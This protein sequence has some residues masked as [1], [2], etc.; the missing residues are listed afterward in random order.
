MTENKELLEQQAMEIHQQLQTVE[1]Q[2][3]DL[4]K[5]VEDINEISK[6]KNKQILVPIHNGVFIKAK[7]EDSENFMVN[8]GSNISVKK[9]KKDTQDLLEQQREE[10]SNYKQQLIN[11][12]EE[13]AKI[14][15]NV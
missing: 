7:L 6:E 1:K 15:Q 3:Q 4:D 14:I 10:L 11:L 8:I 12:F 5:V 9:T 2:M 13:I